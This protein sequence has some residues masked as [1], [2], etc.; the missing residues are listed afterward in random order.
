[1][2]SILKA[3]KKLED[4]KAARRPDELKIDSEILRSSD[5]PSRLSPASAI[6]LSMLLLAGG[7][8]ATYFFMKRDRAP[9]PVIVQAPVESVPN[10]P[11][12]PVPPVIKAERLPSEV[13]VV[14]SASGSKKA[15]VSKPKAD[16][17]PPPAKTATVTAPPAPKPVKPAPAVK[18]V[19]Q[20][21]AAAPAGTPPAASAKGAPA[22]RVTGI[23][24]ND[25]GAD[26]VAMINGVPIS[27]G[28][29]IEGVK[30]VEIH[31]NRVGFSYNG[32]KFEIPLG[33]S[34]R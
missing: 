33:Q 14:P 28:S 9:E 10:R 26:S 25:G 24:F 17:T 8:S 22:L 2:S 4:D 7:S 15:E 6:A 27:S 21:R 11:V 13:P 18:P 20:A 30:V 1:M 19:V 32:E 31:E 3:L 29:S 23:A 5:T 12:V 34:N 16:K